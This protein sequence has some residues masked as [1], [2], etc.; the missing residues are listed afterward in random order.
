M[1]CVAKRSKTNTPLQALTLLNDEAYVEAAM[2]MAARVLN[3]APGRG[4]ASKIEFAMRLAVSRYPTDEE[5]ILLEALLMEEVKQLEK[6]A[7]TVEQILSASEHLTVQ[8]PTDR[9]EWAAWF[10]AC[11]A[12]LN[13]DETISK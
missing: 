2:A 11:S 13:L 6:D 12:I 10:C 9:A 3:E 4:V 5:A 1:T 7:A 8:Q